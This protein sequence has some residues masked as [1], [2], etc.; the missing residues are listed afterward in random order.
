MALGIEGKEG[1]GDLARFGLRALLVA[2]HLPLAVAAHA[3][4][5]DREQLAAEVAARAAQ[6]AEGDLE[7][8]RLSYRVRRQQIVDGLVTADVGQAVGEFEP[9]CDKHRLARMPVVHSAAS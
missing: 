1:L 4:G 3:V 2:A 7:A 8:L 9:F 5:I 6:F